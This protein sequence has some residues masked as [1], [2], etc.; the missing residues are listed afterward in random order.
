MKELL[1]ISI[2]SLENGLLY[3]AMFFLALYLITL[4][5]EKKPHWFLSSSLRECKQM[6]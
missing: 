2:E 1:G 3:I 4:G 6:E 5:I